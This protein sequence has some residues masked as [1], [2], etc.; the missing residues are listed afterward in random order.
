MLKEVHIQN[1]SLIEKAEISFEDGL[2]I[3]TGETGAGKSILMGALSMLLGERAGPDLIRSGCDKAIIEGLFEVGSNDHVLRILESQSIELQDGTMTVRRELSNKGQNRCFLNESMVSLSILKQ[4]GDGLADLHGQH[5]HQSLLRREV[6]IDLLDAFAGLE[7]LRQD[8]GAAY[9][10][11]ARCADSLTELTASKDTRA[12]LLEVYLHELK[13]LDEVAPEAGEDDRLANDERLAANSEQLF[14]AAHRAYEKLYDRE[15]SVLSAL[16]AIDGHIRRLVSL[17]SSWSEW[18]DM[19]KNALISLQEL[20]RELEMYRAKVQYDP[21]RL[22]SIRIRLLQLQR[23]K[24]K[25][26]SLSASIQRQGELRRQVSAADNFAGELERRRKAL[27]TAAKTLMDVGQILSTKRREA[28]VRFDGLVVAE[29]KKLGMDHVVFKTSTRTLESGGKPFGLN[30]TDSFYATRTGTD[31]IEFFLSVNVG[32]DAR[33]LARIASGGEVSRIMLAIKSVL[34]RSD[35][36]PTL[37]F[38]EIDVGISGRIA[39]TVGHS[40]CALGKLRQIICITHLPQVACMSTTH[41]SVVKHVEHG[42]SKTEIRKLSDSEKLLEVAK[43][44]GGSEITAAVMDNAR[45]LIRSRE[46]IR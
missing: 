30:E 21:E 43:L 40:L 36:I 17:D 10:E 26:G 14:D 9:D 8:F 27:F 39:Q 34:A 33:P 22:E 12:A 31:E 18:S 38:D 13:E 3:L 6:H 28:A 29:M 19:L 42:K 46:G 16:H 44:L 32:E 11:A 2:N 37:V 41:F 5:D 20:A 25:Y 24:K 35:R 23:L 1:F 15:D 4:I 7:R 45:E